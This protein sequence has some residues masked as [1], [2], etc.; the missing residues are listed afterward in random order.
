MGRERAPDPGMRW[1]ACLCV[2]IDASD[3]PCVVC[4]AR[5]PPDGIDDESVAIWED[6]SEARRI[7]MRGATRVFIA[8]P[9]GSCKADA[10]W[11]VEHDLL[12]HAA[13]PGSLGVYTWGYGPSVKG[14]RLLAHVARLDAKAE[15]RHGT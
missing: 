1:D 9:R 8:T 3:R 14:R 15:V 13:V 4:E 2:E 10:E 12:E 7:V 11:L 6:L 5:F